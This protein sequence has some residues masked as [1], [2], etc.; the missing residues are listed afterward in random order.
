MRRENVTRM[1]GIECIYCEPDSRASIKLSLPFANRYLVM[2][3]SARQAH[4]HPI[5]TQRRR[6]VVPVQHPVRSHSG[7]FSRQR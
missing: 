6:N 2:T 4:L 1:R 3:N 7:L 5:K